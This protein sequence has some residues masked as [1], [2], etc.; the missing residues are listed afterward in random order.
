[1][2]KVVFVSLTVFFGAAF[3]IMAF[4]N[5][6]SA[7]DMFHTIHAAVTGKEGEGPTI[8]EIM[9]SV[10]LTIGIVVFYNHFGRKKLSTDPTPIQVEMH[11]YEKQINQTLIETGEG[12]TE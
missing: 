4:N 9:Y 7:L 1:M 12:K 10:G 8:V 6:V 5:D 11:A 2:L 3:A